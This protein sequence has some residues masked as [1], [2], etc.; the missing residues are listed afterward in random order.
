VE[1]NQAKKAMYHRGEPTTCTLPKKHISD[2]YAK[3]LS[4]YLYTIVVLV[5]HQGHFSL[6][7]T[8]KNKEN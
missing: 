1:T 4:F 8:E 7:L 6:Q 2:L 3:Y 5:P